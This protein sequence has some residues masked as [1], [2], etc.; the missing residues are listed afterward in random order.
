MTGRWWREVRLQQDFLKNLCE[1]AKY[2]MWHH[3]K[4]GNKSVGI[5]QWE[6]VTD[7]LFTLGSWWEV[8]YGFFFKNQHE[9]GQSGSRIKNMRLVFKGTHFRHSATFSHEVLLGFFCLVLTLLSV[10]EHNG[11]IFS[12]KSHS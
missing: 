12:D 5:L 7:D 1:F 8:L 10:E 4:I 3:F 9:R 2:G 11:R 6:E